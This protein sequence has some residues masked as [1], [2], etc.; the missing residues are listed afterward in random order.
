MKQQNVKFEDNINKRLNAIDEHLDS[1]ISTIQKQML[2]SVNGQ[3]GEQLNEI[4]E[5]F[6]VKINACNSN[7]EC[8]FNYT[9]DKIEEIIQNIDVYET[10]TYSKIS[11]IENN[12]K[13]EIQ[14]I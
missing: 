9:A 11:E 2:D 8:K 12:C 13:M 6:E 14:S 4:K 1:R 10:N 3:F 5:S 7:T